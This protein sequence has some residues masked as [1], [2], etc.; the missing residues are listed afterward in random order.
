MPYNRLSTSKIARAV[1]CHP[2]TVRLYEAEGY[3]PPVPR[4]PRNNYRL[5]T[6]AHLDHMRLAIT[7]LSSPWPGRAIRR[8]LSHLV[9]HAAQGDL[10]GTLE[11]AYHHLALV[12]SERAQAESAAD[13]LEHWAQGASADA[14][15]HP[16]RTADTARLLGVTLDAL[17]TWERNG[18][19]DIPRNPHNRYRQYGPAE[20]G[21]LRV[22]RMLRTAGY[23]LSAILRM[24][25]R[26]D[27]GQTE[28][29]RLV[30]DTPQPDE[31]IFFAADTWL[32]TLVEQETRTHQLISQ[33]Q[34]MLHKQQQTRKVHLYRD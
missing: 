18:L 14:T 1:G 3:L 8:S 17:R 19:V 12:R 27:E 11:L 33:L 2:N 30:L 4:D 24:L 21:R 29:L 6:E 23:S 10:G 32:S 7:A 22:V 16:L 25:T 9:K 28:N 31:D 13:F 15:A 34:D 5:Y 26:L 20:I